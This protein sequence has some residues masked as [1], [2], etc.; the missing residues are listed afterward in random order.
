VVA[1]PVS[2]SQSSATGLRARRSDAGRDANGIRPRRRLGQPL[3]AA[4]LRRVAQR[5]QVARR[6]R[7]LVGKS[8]E[9]RDAVRGRNLPRPEHQRSRK[10]PVQPIRQSKEVLCSSLGVLLCC[11]PPRQ[12]V[13]RPTPSA[14]T[15]IN[16]RG[17]FSSRRLAALDLSGLHAACQSRRGPQKRAKSG[18]SALLLAFSRLKTMLCAQG[19][20]T[21]D[22]GLAVR[23]LDGRLG[24]VRRLRLSNA[25][26]SRL[27]CADPRTLRCDSP[28]RLPPD[29]CLGSQKICRSGS[30]CRLACQSIWIPTWPGTLMRA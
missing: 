23:L 17:G 2:R 18:G 20:I 10:K 8:R 28:C 13:A 6:L 12:I 5:R 1:S 11:C 27:A 25:Q 15:A 7:R 26:R 19:S 4:Q 21:R 16:I 22:F 14:V 9:N 24:Q 30:P 29:R 3:P